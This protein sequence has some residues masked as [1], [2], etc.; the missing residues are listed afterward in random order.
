MVQVAAL[1]MNLPSGYVLPQPAVSKRLARKVE[2]Y[3]E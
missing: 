3:V 2:I 1:E